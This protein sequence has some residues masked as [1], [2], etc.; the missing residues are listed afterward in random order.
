MLKTLGSSLAL[1]ALAIGPGVAAAQIAVVSSTVQEQTVLAGESY[2]GTIL[3]SNPTRQPQAARIYQTDYRFAA[4]GSSHYDPVGTTPRSNAGWVRPAIARLVVPPGATLPVSY[5][6][7]VPADSALRGSYWSMVMVEGEVEPAGA[8]ARGRSDVGLQ[9]VIRYGIQVVSHLRPEGATLVSFGNPRAV[10]VEGRG[11][12]LEFEL[13]NTGERAFR[14]DIRVEIYDETGALR[15]TAN[16][17]RGLL[18][19]GTS[20]LQ[21][22]TIEGVSRRPHQ[23]LIIVDA[24]EAQVFGANY[25]IRP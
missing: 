7:E 18:F 23:A 14:P 24:G 3:V 19:P 1:L 22:F 11:Q 20:L 2:T 6:V 8:P 25:L 16:Q 13:L 21:R 10:Q 5:S 12:Q 9:P 4:D 17:A 15:A